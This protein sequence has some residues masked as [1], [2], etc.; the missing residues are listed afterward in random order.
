MATK[1]FSYTDH[2]GRPLRVRPHWAKESPGEVSWDGRTFSGTEFLKEI[3]RKE[4]QEFKS[5]LGII[6]E[7]GGYRIG[8]L[9]DRFGNLYFDDVLESVWNGGNDLELEGDVVR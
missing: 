3:Y 5:H 2:D 1:W 8:D 6:C 9:R 4:M 7:A